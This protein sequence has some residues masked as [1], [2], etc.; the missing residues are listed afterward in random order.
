M[1]EPNNTLNSLL[2]MLRDLE[3]GKFWGS[4]EL[5]FENGRLMHVKQSQTFKAEDI[6]R[7]TSRGNHENESG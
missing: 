7:R 2:G 4:I 1:T 5:K 6:G 3:Q